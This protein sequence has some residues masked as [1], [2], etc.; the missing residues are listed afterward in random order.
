M[1]PYFGFRTTRRISQFV[2]Q[3]ALSRN[4]IV[5]C[6]N[7]QRKKKLELDIVI[8]LATLA[9]SRGLVGD[10]A[11]ST[12]GVMHVVGRR[13][14]HFLHQ[15]DVDVAPSMAQRWCAG[16]VVLQRPRDRWLLKLYFAS[17]SSLEA[18]PQT[19]GGDLHTG[20]HGHGHN[21]DPRKASHSMISRRREATRKPGSQS[22]APRVTV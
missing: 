20:G 15:V 1:R 14:D 16:D 18:H 10:A 2:Y 19:L 3:Q 9:R 13:I 17:F 21:H 12:I 5:D 8:Y 4:A 6:R 22:W 7:V 11:G